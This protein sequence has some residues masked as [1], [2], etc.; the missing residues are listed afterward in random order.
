[1]ISGDDF[2]LAGNGKE[3]EVKELTAKFTTDVIGS[4]A[5]GLDVNSFKDPNADFRKYG[6]MIFYYNIV[7]GFEM[8]SIFFLPSV[9]RMARVKMMGEK[10]TAFLRKVFWETLTERMKSGEKRNDLIDILIELKQNNSDQN[11]NGFGKYRFLFELRNFEYAKTPC[12]CLI[13]G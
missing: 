12:V 9:V 1:M 4:T 13:T 11:I 3:V 8:L 6:K 10:P 5:F 7:R 2:M